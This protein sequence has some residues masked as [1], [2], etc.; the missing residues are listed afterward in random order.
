VER[1]PSRQPRAP[2]NDEEAA[3]AGNASA[4]EAPNIDVDR[5]Q[6]AT[7]RRLAHRVALLEDQVQQLQEQLDLGV[8]GGEGGERLGDAQGAATESAPTT[9]ERARSHPFEAKLAAEGVDPHWAPGMEEAI[10]RAVAATALQGSRVKDVECLST[11]CKFD[12]EHASEE[13]RDGFAETFAMHGPPRVGEIEIRNAGNSAD[14]GYRSLG[15]LSRAGHLASSV[16][17]GQVGPRVDDAFGVRM[18]E[19]E[20]QDD[21]L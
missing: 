17:H 1:L 16:P 13:A 3:A 19:P 9:E 11:V 15:Y 10:V 6:E 12:V 7:I 5:T 2:A 4:D 14:G 18:P 8:L 21:S 20:E